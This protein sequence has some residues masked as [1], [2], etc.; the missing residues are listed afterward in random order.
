MSNEQDQG[1]VEQKAQ[2]PI[3]VE[4]Q[5]E[6]SVESP[7]YGS[8]IAESKKYR[9]RAQESESKVVKLQDQ[10][11]AIKDQ[12]LVEKEDY[13][14]L[15]EDQKKETAALKAKVEY[16]EGLEKS[17][18]ADALESVPEED[19]EFAED[20]STDKL[21]KFSKRYN[22][23]DVRTDE[24]VAKSSTTGGYS[25]ALEWVTNDP[26]GYAKAKEGTGLKSKFG[27]IFNPSGDS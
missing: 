5:E 18:R 24:S 11:K 12:Q 10:L 9:T 23:K 19:R 27:N 20:M 21:L 8:L 26:V 16:G 3:A 1:V 2:E 13:R 22:L 15:F 7:D 14:T 17:L 4:Q 6:K 25:S